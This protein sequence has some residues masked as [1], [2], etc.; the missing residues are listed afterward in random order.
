[1]TDPMSSFFIMKVIF[2]INYKTKESV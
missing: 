1:M 2:N